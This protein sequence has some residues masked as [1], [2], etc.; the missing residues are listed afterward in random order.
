MPLAFETCDVFTDRRFGGNPLAVVYGADALDGAAMQRLAREFALSETVFVLAP[1]QAGTDAFIRIFTPAVELPFAGHPNVG[2]AR[3]AAGAVGQGL[4]ETP[5]HG[6]RAVP[7]PVAAVPDDLLPANLAAARRAVG[8]AYAP[9]E[10]LVD[11]VV[12]P[13]GALVVL[14]QPRM[15][16]RG[17]FRKTGPAGVGEDRRA[18][19]H[20]PCRAVIAGKI[21][22]LLVGGVAF[23]GSVFVP[24]ADDE[25]LAVG[26]EVQAGREQVLC[27]MA[28]PARG[29][30]GPGD[31]RQRRHGSDVLA[32]IEAQDRTGHVPYG[33][34]PEERGAGCALRR[35]LDHDRATE[36]LT[37]ARHERHAPDE[38][39][40]G[41][42]A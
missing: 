32:R 19:G 20:R 37:A 18:A 40:A 12:K 5:D 36:A 28:R 29:D 21:E 8:T 17:G 2:I 13:G 33:V 27:A 26:M 23:L 15:R 7:H 9:G 3:D 42:P 31:R 34:G 22:Y 11:R 38:A 24:A 4:P 25:E 1:R 14:E 35:Q 10:G 41:Q 16:D 39:H 6:A 30:D